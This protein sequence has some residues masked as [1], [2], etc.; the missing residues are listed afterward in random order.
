[1]EP[2][3]KTTPSGFAQ[4]G[5]AQ[6]GIS[7]T[8]F[9]D[10]SIPVAPRRLV[11]CCD[12]TWQSSVSGLKNVPSNVTRLARSIARSGRED[13]PDGKVWQQIVHY[14]AGIGTG[15]LS[16]A[17]KDRQGGFGIGFVGNV[18]EA[19]NFLVLNYSPGDQIFCFGFSRGAYTARAVAGLVNDIGI[20]SPRDMQDF[21]DLYA[22]YQKNEDSQGFRKSTAY[23][24]WVKGVLEDEQP[25]K[26]ESGF[27]EPPRYKKPPH[28]PAPEASRVVEVVGVFDT[29][30]SLGIPDLTWTQ[31][32]LKFLEQYSGITNPG[33][34]N[35]SLSPYIR[36]AFHALALDERR[37]PFSPTLW[38]FPLD[39]ARGPK[40][41]S[42]SYDAILEDWWKVEADKKATEKQLSAA[43]GA[44]VDCEMY[45]Q[46]KGMESELQQVWFPGVHIN[47][48][49]GSDDPL[50]EWKADF[51]QIALITF[52]WMCE[53][54]SPYLRLEDDLGS[55]ARSAVEDRFNLIQPVLARIREGEKD[56]GFHWAGSWAWKALDM[57][58]LKKAQVRKLPDNAVNGWATGPIVDSFEGKMALAGETIRL[59]GR[60]KDDYTG[61]KLKSIGPTYEFMHPCVHYRKEKD[62][63][64]QPKGL[65][66]LIRKPKKSSDGFEWVS[67]DG[68]TVIPEFVIKPTDHFTRFV[69]MQGGSEDAA[70]DF[71]GTIDKT[72]GF[73]TMEADILDRRESSKKAREAGSQ[74][75]P[76]NQ[77]GFTPVNNGF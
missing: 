70:M 1:M 36:H 18:I 63:T 15:D 35:V 75:G 65:A 37:G 9:I 13:G 44:L 7:Q 2:E 66:D 30:G 14:D 60:Y 68:A 55:V 76:F 32:N 54:V 26:V 59:P 34:H 61:K 64:Y 77:S 48:G 50:K 58:G 33:F 31:Y 27:Q 22:L 38:H 40:K 57:T 51:E 45:D 43:W 72:L 4:G 11:V 49:G 39:G 8:G 69:A 71:I 16:N 46:L 52:A 25:P 47:I 42:K 20:I 3:S 17:E 73:Q 21:P 5:F 10:N 24:E 28:R 62:K 29:V 67:K 53:Q 23:R 56:F 19:Y 6:E 12:G 74:A 41:P